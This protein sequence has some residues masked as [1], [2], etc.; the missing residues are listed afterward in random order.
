MN[1][2]TIKRDIQLLLDL[3]YDIKPINPLNMRLLYSILYF[4]SLNSILG[5]L[6]LDIIRYN[7]F[8][9]LYEKFDIYKNIDRFKIIIE[10]KKIRWVIYFKINSFK[11]YSIPIYKIISNNRKYVN[12]RS[13]KKTIENRYYVTYINWLPRFTLPFIMLQIRLIMNK[14]LKTNNIF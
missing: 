9:Y 10:K 6:P 8:P 4:N 13:I 5:K 14:W 7:L 1:I 3:G 12:L 2:K 11:K